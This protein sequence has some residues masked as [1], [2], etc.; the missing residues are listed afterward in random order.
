MPGNQY[1]TYRYF[2]SVSD[3]HG[4]SNNVYSAGDGEE[5]VSANSASS[6]SSIGKFEIGFDRKECIQ[7]KAI[8]KFD[9]LTTCSNA[10]QNTAQRCIQRAKRIETA[11]AGFSA[12]HNTRGE[13]ACA[14]KKIA[15]FSNEKLYKN[16]I[17]IAFSV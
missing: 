10:N 16:S 13:I 6:T 4:R 14:V 2:V 1:D 8:F 15:I 11:V 12:N 5:L 9:R 17:V 7:C 3:I